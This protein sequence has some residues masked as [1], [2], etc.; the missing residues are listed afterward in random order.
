MSTDQELIDEMRKQLV[1]ME[2]RI[3]ELEGFPKAFCDA[4]VEAFKEQPAAPSPAQDVSPVVSG[5]CHGDVTAGGV[6]GGARPAPH[7]EDAQ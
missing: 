7:S 5:T 4:F 3:Q 6:D 1:A 2:E